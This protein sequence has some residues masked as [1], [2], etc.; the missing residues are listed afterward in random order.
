MPPSTSNCMVWTA[1]GL[2]TMAILTLG[3]A[4]PDLELSRKTSTWLMNDQS[5]V[6]PLGSAVLVIV[7]ASEVSVTLS[8]GPVFI[9]LIFDEMS[10][11][12]GTGNSVASGPGIDEPGTC[13][14]GIAW[15]TLKSAI[16]Q[17]VADAARPASASRAG[18]FMLVVSAKPGD[19]R[20]LRLLDL[21][22]GEPGPDLGLDQLAARDAL[23]HLL[24]VLRDDPAAAGHASEGLLHIVHDGVALAGVAGPGEQ[25]ADPR[26]RSRGTVLRHRLHAL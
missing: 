13:C 14:S 25:A 23:V 4:V 12:I 21:D 8:I 10:R 20:G 19:C 5:S 26:E 7:S 16:P 6:S 24:E 17:A 2:D 15:L 9:A 3:S 1:P 11:S 18:A 22:R